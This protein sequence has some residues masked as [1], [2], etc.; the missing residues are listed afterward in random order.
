MNK[1][2]WPDIKNAFLKSFIYLLLFIIGSVV[3]YEYYQNFINNPTLKE[4]QVKNFQQKFLE[5]E[6][7]AKDIINT[8]GNMKWENAD[9]K[10]L[11]T[12]LISFNKNK[13]TGG[14]EF[15]IYKNDSIF[16]WSSN[17]SLIPE[18][19]SKSIKHDEKPIA[20]GNAIYYTNSIQK[21]DFD[22]VTLFNIKNTYP[23]QN[24]YL[25]NN[26]N[27]SFNLEKNTIVKIDHCLNCSGI[28]NSNGKRV[29]S[30][31]LKTLE[32][33]ELGR[34]RSTFLYF[35]IT[36]LGLLLIFSLIFT[37]N[38]TNQTIKN[39]TVL[40]WIAIYMVLALW[41]HYKVKI[42]F[43]DLTIFAPSLFA[44]SNFLSSLGDLL[45]VAMFFFAASILFYGNFKLPP[46]LTRLNKKISI[47][48]LYLLFTIVFSLVI[49]YMNLFSSLIH[50]SNIS[51]EIYKLQNI[52]VYT[53]FSILSLTLLI[54]GIGLLF[55]KSLIWISKIDAPPKQNRLHI[56][57]V[58]V[59]FASFSFVFI[60]DIVPPI[61]FIVI[62]VVILF[63]RRKKTAPYTM[64]RL[65]ILLLI[66]TFFSVYYIIGQ[67]SE[68]QAV[69]KKVLAVN[70]ATE[71]D[72]I[73]E[74][75]LEEASSK[76]KTDKRLN[77]LLET[78]RYDSANIA[79]H[80]ESRYF[81]GYLEKYETE[82]IIC[83]GNDKSNRSSEDCNNF[84]KNELTGS[85]IMVPNSDFFFLNNPNG[86]IAYIGEIALQR[87]KGSE[88]VSAFIK[89]QSKLIST[90][91]GYPE[92]L[93][94]KKPMR[95]K[96]LF[97]FSHAKYFKGQL[98]SKTGTYPYPLK[99]E[100]KTG[101]EFN[102]FT[103][104]GYNHLEYNIDSQN[105]I[106]ISNASIK[107]TD[108]LFT[109]SYLFSFY[110]IILG[111]A[112]FVYNLQAS[113]TIFIPT[114]RNKIQLSMLMVLV[115]SLFLIGSFTIILSINQYKTKHFEFIREKLQ[116]VQIELLHKLGNQNKLDNTWQ[117]EGYE[118]LDA[119]LKK[120]SNVFFSDIHLYNPEGKLLA[121]SRAEIFSKNLQ[122]PNINP[123]ALHELSENN[124]SEYIHNESI[125]ALDYLSGYIPFFNN[126]GDKLAYL[127]LPYFTRQN[128]LTQEIT[129]LVITM[130]NIYVLLFL[131]TT[132]IAFFM[133]EQIT[134]PLKVIQ[135]SFK[136]VKLGLQN[137]TIDYQRNDEI[138]GLIE[139]YNRMVVELSENTAKLAKSEREMAWREMAR[140]IA[141][142]I[143]NPLTPMKLNIQQLQ[144][145]WK[146]QSP[147]RDEMIEKVCTTIID[148]INSLSS[149]ATEFSNFAKMPQPKNEVVDIITKIKNTVKLFDQTENLEFVTNF[150]NNT[151]VNIYADKEQVSR[152]FINLI[153]NGIQA[154]KEDKKGI[155]SINVKTDGKAAYIEICDNGRG[156]PDE[157]HKQLFQPNFTTKSSGMGLGLAIVKKIIE[158]SNGQIKFTTEINKGTCFSIIW[159]TFK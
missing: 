62:F 108:I 40:F 123:K 47:A 1:T 101:Q 15:L 146:K 53:V 60:D 6:K 93:I 134:R 9:P 99:W 95:K 136:K 75:L 41:F 42:Q 36:V 24:K 27:K 110:F 25:R 64:S 92:L 127:N 126:N 90:E 86:R 4:W 14:I 120:F 16:F 141:H 78:P 30:V 143:K 151:E 23:I 104:E 49:W 81:K 100:G 148:Q 103:D 76:I 11:R 113:K 72:Y 121:S 59:L 54:I 19:F 87:I 133:S 74:I 69:N 107:S 155:I 26:Y 137:K 2:F 140:Q 153:K 102:N 157:I 142:E 84:I 12:K 55:D 29:L 130:L 32:Q 119:L 158:T 98:I 73:A 129:N 5:K 61:F 125:G 38:I 67:V 156:I 77:N 46:P 63:Y 85:E 71:H 159:E 124:R 65:I 50:N 115:L 82:V 39:Y 97:D 150:N 51:F 48:R 79:E 58:M 44:S 114:F 13:K 56:S 112:L 152:V 145:V 20:L 147:K 66:Y 122:S 139:E 18:T 3:V 149:I 94:N 43:I 37:R 128:L 135:E 88:K 7:Q 33:S 111:I 106:I 21:G 109:F 138:A 83:P 8:I 144:R 10:N 57:L 68:K 80:I 132:G 35:A 154:I 105:I 96:V 89:I 116:S 17:K 117:A 34:F 31:E 45:L 52:D 131:I 22:L 118:N 28:Y 70:L 91:L